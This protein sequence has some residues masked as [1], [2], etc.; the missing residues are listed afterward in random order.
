MTVVNQRLD[1][2]NNRVHGL[3]CAR[4]HGSRMN[5]QTLGVDKVFLDVA[6]SDDVIGHTFLI[7]LLDNFVV[8]IRKVLHELDVI[9]A[10]LKI[11]AQ[12]I[13]NNERARV[14]D[15]EIVVH[16]RAAG[17]HLDLARLQRDKLFLFARHRVIQFHNSILPL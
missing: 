17:V 15:V 8:N 16:S 13:K 6:V 9:A 11:A 14:A 4:M 2:V 12:R 7:C 3:G 10:V 1:D 5:A